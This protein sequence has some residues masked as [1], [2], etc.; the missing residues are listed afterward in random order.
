MS[1]QATLNLDAP[2]ASGNVTVNL[3]VTS[4]NASDT[5]TRTFLHQPAVAIQWFDLGALT[6]DPRHAGRG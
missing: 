6:A 5:E 2:Q 3:L 4:G 1:A